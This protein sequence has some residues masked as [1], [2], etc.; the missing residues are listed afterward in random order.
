[1]L[2]ISA[3][4]FEGSVKMLS[5]IDSFGLM[6]NTGFVLSIISLEAKRNVPSPPMGTTRS[7]QFVHFD[8]SPILCHEVYMEHKYSKIII[9]LRELENYRYR[10]SVTIIVKF[11]STEFS[12]NSRLSL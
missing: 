5:C 3:A 1:M 12:K 6:P 4:Y 11:D 7:A 10:D 8:A 2:G 9:I